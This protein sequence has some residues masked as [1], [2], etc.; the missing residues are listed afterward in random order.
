MQQVL[1]PS[2]KQLLTPPSAQLPDSI[3][4]A[5]LFADASPNNFG[6][7]DQSLVTMFRITA[8]MGWAETLPAANPD[9]SLNYGGILF[10]SSY[11]LVVNWILLQVG[12]AT[13]PLSWA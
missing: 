5:T 6:R 3:L 13:G 9:G 8:G 4:G 7:F 10:I 11:I 12:V 1:T 2:S